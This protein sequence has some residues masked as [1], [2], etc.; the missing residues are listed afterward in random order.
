[1][2]CLGANYR[3]LISPQT[4]THVHTSTV[5]T[6]R[7]IAKPIA[8]HR[9]LVRVC[10]FVRWASWRDHCEFNYSTVLL[11]VVP[12]LTARLVPCAAP[13]CWPIPCRDPSTPTHAHSHTPESYVYIGNVLRYND[14]FPH[15]QRHTNPRTVAQ[16]KMNG[17]RWLRPSL[18]LS[19][20]PWL[21]PN[22]VH[23]LMNM[24]ECMRTRNIIKWS[25]NCVSNAKTLRNF[26][27]MRIECINDSRRW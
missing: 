15:K 7:S 17:K 20:S 12:V 9:D 23:Q 16:R 10:A 5:Y 25:S 3:T 19:L 1:M 11:L 21:T 14:A 2:F 26:L 13:P 18:P 27:M 6:W 24:A 8:S 22:C 4:H